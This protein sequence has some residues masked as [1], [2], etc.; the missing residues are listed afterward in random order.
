MVSQIDPE[1]VVRRTLSTHLKAIW[2]FAFA[3]SGQADTAD[4]LVQATCVRA[5]EKCHQVT[6]DSRVDA[7]CMTICRSIWLNEIRAQNIRR[8]QSLAHAPDAALIDPRE[9][10]ETNFLAREVFTKVMELP[11]AQRV[12]VMLVFVEGYA[13]REA[14]EVLQVPI[15][16]IMSRLSAARGK[17]RDMVD[18]KGNV[19]GGVK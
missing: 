8:T 15:G 14:A 9:D 17:L 4:D 6:E 16:T 3:L 2:R 18:G 11:E 19:K 1:A 12:T 5:L 10:T 13:Y 7:W